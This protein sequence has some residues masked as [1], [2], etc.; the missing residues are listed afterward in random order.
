MPD[1]QVGA[2]GILVRIRAASI[3]PLDLKLRDGAFKA[4]LPY[5]LPLILGNDLAAVVVQMG[6]AVT[7]FAVG[8]EV[9]ARPVTAAGPAVAFLLRLDGGGLAWRACRDACRT[10]SGWCPAW[11]GA[12]RRRPACRR[13]DGR[14]A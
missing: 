6:S 8:D 10:R 4:I 5:R 7:R 1:P 12:G 9:Y 3:N 13:A 11:A 2:D 14:V